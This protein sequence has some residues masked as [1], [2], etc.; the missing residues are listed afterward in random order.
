MDGNDAPCTLDA[1]L[2]KECGCDDRAG[3]SVGVRVE[4][5]A[6]DDGDEDDGETTAKY[7]RTITDY[8]TASHSS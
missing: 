4:E 8:C 5:S 7:L 1:E 6:S 3:G 2:L